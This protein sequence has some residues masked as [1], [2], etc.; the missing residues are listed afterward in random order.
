MVEDETYGAG[1]RINQVAPSVNGLNTGSTSISTLDLTLIL[2]NEQTTRLNDRRVNQT[3]NDS[4][5]MRL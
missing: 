4:S 1:F 5:V 3:V 2:I